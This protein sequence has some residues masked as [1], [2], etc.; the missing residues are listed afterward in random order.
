[1]IIIIILIVI[2]VLIYI[3][4]KLYVE[5]F[6]VYWSGAPVRGIVPLPFYSSTANYDKSYGQAQVP[7]AYGYTNFPFNN[8]RLGQ[9]KNMSYD[10]R[11]DPLIIPKYPFMWNYSTLTPIYNRSI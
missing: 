2:L 9:T 5:E 10:L 3:Y 7:M 8:T 1:M 11:G 6:A 4:N